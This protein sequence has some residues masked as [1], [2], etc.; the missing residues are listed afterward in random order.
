YISISI[1]ND[2]KWT[3]SRDVY[4]GLYSFAASQ[5]RYSNDEVTWSG[6]EPYSTRRVWTLTQG[7]E[8]KYVYYECKKT[9]GDTEG[10]A[11][12]SI[13]FSSIPPDPP[14]DL[15]ITINDGDDYTTSKRVHLR[16]R[17]ENANEC[18]YQQDDYGWTTWEDYTTSRDLT[19]QGGDGLKTIYYQCQ[20]DYGKS[21]THDTIHL[22]AGPPGP[23]YDL[24][25]RVGYNS[26]YLRWSRP[27]GDVSGFYIYRSTHS[28]GLFSMIGSTTSTTYTDSQVMPG[29]GYSYYVIVRSNSGQ[30]SRQSNVVSADIPGPLTDGDAPAN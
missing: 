23:V 28:L 21:G 2:A 4:L 19:L 7:E 10:P 11:S 14:T 20:N 29:E 8:T 18:R 9:N 6:W 15:S 3:N 22:D 1:N 13:I 26:V 16:L 5:C 25:A 27:S 12:A 30:E 17:A 24:S